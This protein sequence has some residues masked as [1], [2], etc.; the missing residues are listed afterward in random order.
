M[1]VRPVANNRTRGRKSWL[2]WPVW[3]LWSEEMLAGA[4]GCDDSLLSAFGIRNESANAERAST[5]FS[6][7]PTL[8][9]PRNP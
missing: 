1:L 9:V 7:A 4:F 2:V 5:A 3:S 6:A 8:S